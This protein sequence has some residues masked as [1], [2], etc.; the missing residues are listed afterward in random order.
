MKTI[1]LIGGMSWE[2]SIEYYRMIN[3][4]V[5][6]QL[7]GLHSAK[8][9]MV[10]VDFAEIEV[11]Q[12]QGRWEAAGELLAASARSLQAGGADFIVLCTNTMHKVAGEIQAGVRIPFLHIADAAGKAVRAASFRTVGLLGTRF[13]LDED[14]ITRPLE[15]KY[16]LTVLLPEEADRQAVHDV[17]FKE[18]CLGII[19][20]ESRKRYIGIID[21][22]ARQGAEGVILA[23][24]E[25][26]LLVRGTD[27]PVPLFPTTRLHALAA[28]DFAFS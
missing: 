8:S 22:L 14:F 17:I 13:T 5:K 23:C 19:R 1:G 28:V 3:Q 9:V 18:L 26:E 11:L 25:I 16:G 10:S 4:L 7:G 15:E 24:T 12:Q 20:P 2:S 21:K 27:T 6:A